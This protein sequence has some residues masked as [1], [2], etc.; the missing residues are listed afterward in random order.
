MVL[1]SSFYW[2]LR[3]ASNH[4]TLASKASDFTSLST[5]K[6]IECRSTLTTKNLEKNLK[7]YKRKYFKFEVFPLV[8]KVRI[9]LTYNPYITL[10]YK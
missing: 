6:Y 8:L 10:A 1:F 5:Q 2:L 3:M 7:K 9:E 4:Q